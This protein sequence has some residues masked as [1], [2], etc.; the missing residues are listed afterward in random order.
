M[1]AKGSVMEV[2][3][4]EKVTRL[5]NVGDVVNVKSGYG[6]NFLIPRE[7]AVRAT[8]RNKKEFEAKKEVLQ[9]RS[10]AARAEAQKIAEKLAGVSVK[11]VRQAS[12][13]GKLYGSVT[14]R[15]VAIALEDA[16]HKIE[17]RMINLNDGIKSLGLYKATVVFHAEVRATI[18]VQVVRSLEATAYD[19][20]AKEAQAAE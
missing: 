3:L 8:E 7:K 2:I 19:V 5:G 13:D 4:L 9:Q 10:D 20:I 15:D 14:A 16:G 11:I 6:R 17:R 18:D 12:E 1:K